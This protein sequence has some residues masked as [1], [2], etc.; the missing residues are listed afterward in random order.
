[1]SKSKFNPVGNLEI[2]KVYKDGTREIHWDDHNVI[3]SGMGVGLSYLFSLSGSNTIS[4]FQIA[5]FQAGTGGDVNDYGASTYALNT[6]LI[7]VSGY[8]PYSELVLEELGPLENGVVASNKTF[9]Q[10]RFSN[11]H[12]VSKNSVRYTL[13][14]DNDTANNAPDEIDEVGLFMRNPLG[15]ATSSPILVAYRPFTSIKKTDAFSLVFLWTLQ[16]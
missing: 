8:G 15:T 10:I 3:T 13:V 12:K 1:M 14:L 11:I 6:P 5:Y 9:A 4:D 2:W 7:S 16:F